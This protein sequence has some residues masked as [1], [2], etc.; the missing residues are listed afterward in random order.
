MEATKKDITMPITLYNK[1]KRYTVTDISI[2]E[3]SY[4][5]SELIS[6]KFSGHQI[7]TMNGE[8]ITGDVYEEFYPDMEA[9]KEQMINIFYEKVDVNQ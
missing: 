3:M 2:D 6:Y 1:V 9:L 8:T 4:L 7:Y 5:A